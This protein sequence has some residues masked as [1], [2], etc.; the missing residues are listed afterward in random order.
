MSLFSLLCVHTCLV[1][2]VFLLD[3]QANAW[4]NVIT[5]YYNFSLHA[6]HC[7]L[8]RRGR[9]GIVTAVCVSICLEDN[10]RT[11][12]WMSTKLGRHGQGVTLHKW[13]NFGIIRFW[14]WIQDYFSTFL[15]TRESILWYSL[16]FCH[17]VMVDFLQVWHAGL[18][19]V[20]G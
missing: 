11:R 9:A 4:T 8:L 19:P 18:C 12:W 2:F 14:M 17:A 13:L 1:T 10:L 6:R 16:A 7:S 20:L 3:F 5:F 15:N